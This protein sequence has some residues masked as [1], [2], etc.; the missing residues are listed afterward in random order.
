MDGKSS[1]FADVDSGVTQGTVLGLC[2]F[3]CISMIY[4]QQLIQK[5]NFLLMIVYY[6]ERSNNQNDLQ[7]DLNYL[8]AWASDCGMRL[9]ANKCNNKLTS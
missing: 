9:N 7:K 5:F 4:H 6:T 3:F 8:Q 1:L 2:F